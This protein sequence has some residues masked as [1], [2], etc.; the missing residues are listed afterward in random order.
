MLLSK[1]QKSF[2]KRFVSISAFIGG[3][4]CFLPVVLVLLGLSTVSFAAS[5]TDI[6]YGQYK[7]AFRGAA[8]VFLLGSLFWYL[9]RKE[10]ICTLDDLK[11][12]KILIIN[13]VTI[14]LILGVLA[15]II[16]LYGIVEI[17]G[18]ILNIW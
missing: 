16:W 10:D 17:M 4:C 8:L 5:L 15:Y 14:S 18:I 6:L 1:K 11:R 12:K 7:W 3:L 13:L 9:Y 2:L